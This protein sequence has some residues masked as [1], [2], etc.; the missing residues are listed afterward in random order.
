MQD[1]FNNLSV[2]QL[3]ETVWTDEI[4]SFIIKETLRYAGTK[5]EPFTFGVEDLKTFL[6]ILLLSGYKSVTTRKN[7]L[8]K[9]SRLKSS[10]SEGFL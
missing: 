8:V 10:T 1:K 4:N 2:V 5:N 9:R 3:F 7:V 6:E